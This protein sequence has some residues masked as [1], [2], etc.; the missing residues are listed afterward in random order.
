MKG[1]HKARREYAVNEKQSCRLFYTGIPDGVIL[2][3]LVICSRKPRNY[4]WRYQRT[5]ATETDPVSQVAPHGFGLYWSE[6]REQ[7]TPRK[8]CF[9]DVVADYDSQGSLYIRWS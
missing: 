2:K 9:P 3:A 1:V 7:T 6:D 4:V 5:N 8:T